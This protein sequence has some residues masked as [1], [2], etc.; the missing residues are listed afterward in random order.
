VQK[1]LEIAP[2]PSCA[3][4]TAAMLA[5]AQYIREHMQSCDAA[6]RELPTQLEA[7]ARSQPSAAETSTLSVFLS[8]AQR[9]AAA[10]QALAALQSASFARLTDLLFLPHGPA[11]RRP[12][13]SASL[14]LTHPHTYLRR[15]ASGL[16]SADSDA[17][18]RFLFLAAASLSH[19]FHA[20]LMRSPVCA[21]YAPLWAI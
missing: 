18:M 21:P 16:L 7:F 5:A 19:P 1:L 9:N 15:S 4:D 3:S 13:S 17:L 6:L 11:Q 14:A 10:P 20:L 12:V 8:C 2:K